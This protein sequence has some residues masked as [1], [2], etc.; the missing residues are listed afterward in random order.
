MN[1]KVTNSGHV[2]I[3]PNIR[4]VHN[5]GSIFRTSDAVG[6]KKIYLV[7]VTPGPLDRFLRK[8]KDFSK[9]SLGAEDSVTW[10]S[11]G[12]MDDLVLQLKQDGYYVVALEQDKNSVDYKKISLPKDKKNFAFLLGEET[13]GLSKD[14]LALADVIAEIPMAGDK[15]SLNVAVAFGVAVFRLLDQ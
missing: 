5:V 1:K 8:R 4:S 15:E 14:E 6:I 11:V 3:L 13:K 2:V 9:V 10:E 12:D 7:G